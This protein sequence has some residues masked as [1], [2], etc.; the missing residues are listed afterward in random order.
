MSSYVSEELRRLVAN[1]AE[2]LCEYCLIGEDD[3][4]FGCEVDH[5]V[6]LKHSG[7]T[8][9]INLAY[10]CSF[11]N[12]NKGSDIAS[13][14]G[15]AGELVRFFNPR[16]DL[17]SEHFRLEGSLIEPLTSVGEATARILK[18]NESERVLERETLIAIGRYPSKPASLRMRK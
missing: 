18:F 9:A 13:L 15:V 12:R 8:E 17:W 7:P 16:I 2:R 1:R 5:I 10:A 3:T 4:F 11:C 14:S 6:S